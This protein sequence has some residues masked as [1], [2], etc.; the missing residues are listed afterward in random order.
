MDRQERRRLDVRVRP[1]GAEG[2]GDLA[3]DAV[4]TR[5]RGAS[6]PAPNRLL[7]T[8]FAYD[9]FGNLIQ[10]IEAANFANDARTTDFS[11]DV[12]GRLVGTLGHGYYD[13]GTGRVEKGPGANRFRQETTTIFASVWRRSKSRLKTEN[14]PLWPAI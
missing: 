5:R 3:A 8:R 9:A 4:Q 12:V 13:P 10:K 1:Q 11:Y 6:T 14:T 7:E 2:Q